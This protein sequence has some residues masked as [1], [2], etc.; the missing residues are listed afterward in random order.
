MQTY[1]RSPSALST[2][3]IAQVYSLAEQHNVGICLYGGTQSPSQG[4][5]EWL[6]SGGVSSLRRFTMAVALD[7]IPKPTYPEVRWSDKKRWE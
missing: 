7:T 2:A 4:P 3:E 5:A 6:V 1:L